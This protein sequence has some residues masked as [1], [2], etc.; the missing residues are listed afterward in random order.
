MAEGWGRSRSTQCLETAA[1]IPVKVICNGDNR[2]NNG[3]GCEFVVK[4]KIS[5]ASDKTNAQNDYNRI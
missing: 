1:T 4:M 5:I 3:P 2:K